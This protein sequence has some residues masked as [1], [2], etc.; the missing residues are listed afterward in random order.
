MFTAQRYYPWTPAGE[1]ANNKKIL[2]VSA[3]AVNA[4]TV[5][6]FGTNTAVRWIL[7]KPLVTN[8]VSATPSAGQNF[9]WN[10]L[11]ADLN[12]TASPPNNRQIAAGN[13]AFQ[14]SFTA[15]T[16]DLLSSSYGVRLLVHKRSA[17]GVLTQ[18]GTAADSALQAIPA[19]F[20]ANWSLTYAGPEMLFDT[21]E[22]LH[23]E[24]W[25]QGRGGG[26]T[27][28]LAQ[29]VTFNIG[30]APLLGQEMQ[31]DTPSPGIRTRFL[32]TLTATVRAANAAMGFVR[33]PYTP[34]TPGTAT[35]QGSVGSAGNTYSRA[36]IVNET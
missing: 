21:D 15:L 28:L 23:L 11:T 24:F 33:F 18:I 16:V 5:C 14:G 19:T 13:W 31:F 8:S 32:R 26:A 4:A 22:T 34:L 17:T 20:L 6:D 2:D 7:A 35:N 29:T 3:G 10:I 27:G 30:T 25:L 9:G 36:R 12:N 1:G